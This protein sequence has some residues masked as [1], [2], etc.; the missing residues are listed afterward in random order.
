MG[1]WLVR[2][3]ALREVD[4]SQVGRHGDQARQ[5]GLG[6]LT[7]HVWELKDSQLQGD[8]RPVF[9]QR[10][11]EQ[12]QAHLGG[13]FG[14]GI[15]VDE[16]AVFA[17]LGQEV[18]AFA[19]VDGVNADAVVSMDNRLADKH[20]DIA[21]TLYYISNSQ[22]IGRQRPPPPRYLRAMRQIPQVA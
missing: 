12:A 8:S 18:L 15:A 17:L 14:V 21:F 7:G 2:K 5:V 10:A 20:E 9:T 3:D 22:D 19:V 1:R 13:V 6:C 11:A 16:G 4:I